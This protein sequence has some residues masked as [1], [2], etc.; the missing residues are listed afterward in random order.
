MDRVLY[1]LA[2]AIFK[3]LYEEGE[4]EK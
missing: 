2:T 4:D 3:A 1:D